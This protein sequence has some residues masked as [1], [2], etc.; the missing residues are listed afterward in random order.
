MA[1]TGSAAWAKMSPAARARALE[2]D[3]EVVPQKSVQPVKAA[4]LLAPAAPV[5]SGLD[6]L[7]FL[8]AI[9]PNQ[10]ERRGGV[11]LD[12]LGKFAG[13]SGDP[14][15]A[16]SRAAINDVVQGSA[17]GKYF[18]NEGGVNYAP[19]LS[20]SLTYNQ[21]LLDSLKGYTFTPTSDAERT[22]YNV[23]APDGRTRIINWGTADSSFDKFAQQAI[24]LAIAALGGAALGG[25]IPGAEIG[26]ASGGAAAGG[27]AAADIGALG[28]AE[29]VYGAGGALGAGAVPGTV[30]GLA[31]STVGFGGLGSVL[32]A[33][34]GYGAAATGA[35]ALA[36]DFGVGADYFP[37]AGDFGGVDAFGQADL[38]QSLAGGLEPYVPQLPTIGAEATAFGGLPELSALAAGVP[39]ETAFGAFG[40]GLLSPE[41]S[42]AFGFDPGALPN[43]NPFGGG[44]A[45][46]LET[47]PAIGAE[48]T[49]FGALPELSALAAG[50]PIETAFG[51]FGGGLLAAPLPTPTAEV[52]NAAKDSQAYNAANNITTPVNTTPPATVNLGQFD[53][54]AYTG[55]TISTG[56]P[57]TTGV[58]DFRADEIKGYQ[59][60]GRLPGSAAVA[61]STGLLSGL[62]DA[63]K[64][65][66]D[67]PALGR[68]LLGGATGLLSSSG[69]NSSG[70]PSAPSGP[71]V[72][73]N[74]GLQQGLLTP[75]QQYAPAAITQNKPA[76]LLAQGFQ[77]D[78]AWRYL[79]G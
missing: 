27:A 64:W 17:S 56:V 26:A 43:A 67:N 6:A 62:G 18:A 30:G 59:T 5:A 38:T 7:Q 51:A 22:G 33:S 46:T 55:G 49:A 74:S 31:G 50:A 3:S 47:L 15:S 24:P 20:G 36:A 60:D 79:K 78:G 41:A 13:F 73:W 66:K 69:S 70:A 8:K 12:A 53:N 10:S 4:G 61:G 52:F 57:P 37:S 32:P 76:G 75:V 35:G 40:G 48:T 34:V 14:M 54:P 71:P 77:N 16:E 11:A 45:P 25:F 29:G 72:S 65:L 28:L 1:R 44:L 42:V 21:Q 68:L 58:S 19:E 9:Q 63:A 2:L 39:V 23:T